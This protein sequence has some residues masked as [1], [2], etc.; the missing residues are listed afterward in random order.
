MFKETDEHAL[1][2]NTHRG[3]ILQ[4]HFTIR[5]SHWMHSYIAVLDGTG[6]VTVLVGIIVWQL[7]L[8]KE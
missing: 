2:L 5:N 4:V 1:K 3:R 6:G 7:L 8:I